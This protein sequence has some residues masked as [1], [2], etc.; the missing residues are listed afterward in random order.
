MRE[1]NSFDIFDTLLARKV[2]HPTYI[3]DIIERNYPYQNFKNLRIHSE[4][5]SDGTIDSIYSN[6]QILTGESNEVI[7][8]LRVFELKT[9]MENTIPIVSNINKIKDNDIL[10]SDMYLTHDEIIKLLNY[11]HINPNITLF[12]S[13]G[14]KSQGY[15]WDKLI[16]EFSIKSHL[17]DNYH[18]DVVMASRYN[19]NGIH[20]QIHN[21]S[22]LESYLINKDVDLCSF[23]RIFRLMNPYNEHTLQYKI[24]DEQIQYN[25]PLL[26]FMCRKLENIL[27]H[28]NRNT[29]LFLSR[30]GC[31]IYKIF[32]FLYPQYK[33]IYMYS[34]R[35]INKNYNNDYIMYLKEIYNK[36][37]CLLFDL[38][39]CFES[40]RKMFM[41][42]FDH[43]PRIFI[44]SLSK[45]H[46][47]YDGITYIL[48]EG[49]DYIEKLNKDFRGSL[50]D[51]K[52][53]RPIFMPCE[54]NM[55]YVTIINKT[56]NDFIGYIKNKSIILN[57][58]IFNDDSL[59]INYKNSYIGND[60]LPHVEEH[61]LYTLTNL[62]NKYN[63]DKGTTYK[64]AH[65]YCVKYQEIISDLLDTHSTN[66]RPMDLLEIG[67]NRD[68]RYSIPSL[69]IWNDYFYGNINITGFDIEDFLQ[70]NSAY[71]N[72]KI[73]MGDQSNETDL[74]QLKYKTYDI[75]VDDGYHAS[76]H[77]QISFKKL[78]EN[79]KPGGYYVIEDLHYQPEGE[80]E[81][82][83]KTKFLFENWKEDNWINT[84]FITTGD[85]ENIKT[86]IQSIEFYDSQSKLW[87]DKVKNAFVYIKKRL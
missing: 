81:N 44:F 83:T 86:G 17:G 87:G 74:Q 66:L 42:V 29:V 38:N 69:M 24:Y 59:W 34:S 36:D 41:D 43:L 6:F 30:D 19:I 60:I 49:G 80:N 15:M 39:G 48:K 10:V 63:S 58:E 9:E 79:V 3:F 22:K 67:L 28:E 7:H 51:F 27:I 82:C 54:I 77:Q 53:G 61:S 2:Q 68:D 32:S 23:F 37:D 46:L 12:V 13:P 14:G 78:W 57:N 84:E 20:T 85:V 18:S 55:E 45:P 16:K 40:G 76:K 21:F 1:V 25:L 31:L 73:F 72:I 26:L 56:I 35:Q 62:A 4:S 50:V 65:N 52:N 8:E 75:I 47:Y 11:H 64:C 33:S 71:E 70:F 5:I